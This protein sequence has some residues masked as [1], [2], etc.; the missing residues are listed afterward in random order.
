MATKKKETAAAVDNAEL[1]ESV[2][3][4]LPEKEKAAEPVDYGP[5]GY[6][7]PHPD[8]VEVMIPRDRENPGS[9]QFVSYNGRKYGIPRD[10]KP[11]LVPW[12]VAQVIKDAQTQRAATDDYID[13]IVTSD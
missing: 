10:G 4:P 11:H 8:K 5:L 12:A 3:M 9:T 7:N 1:E 2:E 13:S 6:M